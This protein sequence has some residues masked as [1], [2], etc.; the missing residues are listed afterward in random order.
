M[1]QAFTLKFK[2]IDFLI[3]TI[4]SAFMPNFEI[5]LKSLLGSQENA[6]S[7]LNKLKNVD[8]NL[9]LTSKNSQ[10][11]HYFIGGDINR[12]SVLIHEHLDEFEAQDFHHL[13]N[14]GS[15]FSV[16]TRQLDNQIILVIKA[17]IDQTSSSNGTARIE[18]EKKFENM[19]LKDLDQLLLDTDFSYQAKWSRVREEYEFHLPHNFKS[20]VKLLENPKYVTVCLDKNAGYGY[21]TEFELVLQ[22]IS[23]AEAGKTFLRDLIRFLEVQ[24]LS[25]DKLE[26]MF[27]YYN[28]NWTQYYGT[29]KTFN[30]E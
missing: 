9:K 2:S 20:E 13:V 22:D 11:N 24:E 18:F 19:S 14:H 30:L 21:L 27:V 8:K 4:H 25:Q 5:E 28:A 12:L 26:R 17:S 16:R 15:N 29:D 23:E 7:F 3:F 6:T 1:L 10:L